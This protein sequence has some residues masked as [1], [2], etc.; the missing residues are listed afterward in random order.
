MSEGAVAWPR[1][2][3]SHSFSSSLVPRKES[4]V[5]RKHKKPVGPLFATESTRKVPTEPVRSFTPK[6]FFTFSVG[7][8]LTLVLLAHATSFSEQSR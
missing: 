8:W 4:P 6:S 5:S 1:R 7:T 3:S 2:V